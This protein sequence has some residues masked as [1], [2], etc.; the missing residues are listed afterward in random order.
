[1]CDFLEVRSYIPEPERARPTKLAGKPAAE[2]RAVV[3]NRRRMGRT[4]GKGLQRR[5]SEVVERTFA[6]VCETGGARRTHLR[7]LADVT[8]RYRIAAAAHNLGRILRRLTGVGKPRTLQGAAGGPAGLPSR[9]WGRF[10]GRWQRWTDRL[11]PMVAV[12]RRFD[13]PT[14]T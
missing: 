9:L 13:N 3:N 5:R 12:S 4:K 7:G 11:A 6:H 8:K 1:M 2:R 14:E 10:R